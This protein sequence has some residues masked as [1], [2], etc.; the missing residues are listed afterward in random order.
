MPSGYWL[1]EVPGDPAGMRRLAGQLRGDASSIT[2]VAGRISSAVGSMTF[3]GPAADRLRGDSRIA[4][5]GIADNSE[6]LTSVARMLDESAE[7]VER[8][9]RE[10]LERMA[11]MNRRL[12]AERAAAAGAL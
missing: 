5:T 1:P 9:Q 3:E 2:A 12:E 8:L 6:R 4:T 11:E 7:E 10:R